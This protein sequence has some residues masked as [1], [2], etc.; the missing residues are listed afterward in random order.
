M[1]KTVIT[2]L[3]FFVLSTT[4]SQT[5][6]IEPPYKKFPSY[7]P[8]KLLL[9][10]SSSYFTKEDLSKKLPVLL[11][12]FNPQCEHCQHE[13]EG[14]INNISRLKNVQIVMATTMPF[15]SMMAFRKKYNLTNY[16]NIIVTR[17]THYF[18]PV[19]F[20]IRNLPFLAFYNRKKELI[21]VF[22]GSMPIERVIETINK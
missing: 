9:P 5:N 7:P 3:S 17:D 20:D 15:D 19:F 1:K 21:E 10:D 12:L 6:P 8:A 14:I 11:M 22:E 16:K 18:L 13:T 2:I 4:F